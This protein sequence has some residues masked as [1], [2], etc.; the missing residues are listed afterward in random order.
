MNSKETMLESRMFM[1]MISPMTQ[2]S[3][4]PWHKDSVPSLIDHAI[5]LGEKTIFHMAAKIHVFL[6]FLIIFFSNPVMISLIARATL[7]VPEPQASCS[8]SYRT[9]NV[10]YIFD[11]H[12]DQWEPNKSKILTVGFWAAAEFEGFLIGM[13]RFSKEFVDK[14]LDS[15]GIPKRCWVLH[16]LDEKT[17]E[18]ELTR[19]MFLY[20]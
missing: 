19:H 10:A 1:P 18:K 7:V 17:C 16:E 14:K 8:V 4:G 13:I 3:D 2:K 9:E 15:N 11:T 6:R 5:I 12:K 20:Y